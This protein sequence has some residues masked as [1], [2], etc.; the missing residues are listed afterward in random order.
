MR[1]LALLGSILLTVA[2]SVVAAQGITT[3]YERAYIDGDIVPEYCP[4]DTRH[5]IEVSFS[6]KTLRYFVD[7]VFTVEFDAIT[8][9]PERLNRPLC[10]TVIE[11]V[12]NPSWGPTTPIRR[13]Y[14]TEYG[15][16]LPE[17]VPPGHKWNAM[18][19]RKFIVDWHGAYDSVARVHGTGHFPDAWKET[20]TFGCIRLL[21]SG[22]EKLS[23]MLR[24][25]EGIEVCLHA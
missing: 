25:E 23:D 17:H 1:A 21:N 8:P 18:G 10:G 2:A 6:A 24:V 4:V 20:E 13:F 5:C 19:T 16:S 9:P 11:I 22:I 3:E 15:I 12:F 7:N 14:M